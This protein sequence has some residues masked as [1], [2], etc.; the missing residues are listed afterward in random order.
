LREYRD[1]NR[2]SLELELFSEEPIY[3]DFEQVKL[4]DSLGWMCER[5]GFQS[6]IVQEVLQ[7][8]SPRE[9]AGEMVRGTRLKDVAARKSYYKN[10]A[11]ELARAADPMIELACKVDA[12]ARELR[13]TAETQE[14]VKKQAYAKIARARFAAEKT[15]SYPDATFTLRLAFGT[16]SGYEEDGRKIPFQ[17]TYQ[18]LYE[19]S[20]AHENQPPFDLPK[21]WLDR[22]ARLNPATPF[23]FVSTAD[24]IGGNSGSPVVNRRGEFVGI[25][26]DGNIQSL[27]LDYLYTEKQARAV[28]VCS[29]SII[30]ALRTVYDAGEIA[31][32]LLGKS[33]AN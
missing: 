30:E 17:T 9:R 20:A 26:F 23:N 22:K 1:S 21:L 28:S 3:D 32:E 33:R 24:I 16:V 7:G 8:K 14:E 18:G 29:Q 13:K 19:R 2:E 6:P 11:N 10:S 5:L 12:R 31:D 4:A 15:G 25:I 27:V